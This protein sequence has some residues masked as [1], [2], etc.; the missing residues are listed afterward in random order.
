MHPKNS[1]SVCH[2]P[3]NFSVYFYFDLLFYYIE[4]ICYFELQSCNIEDDDINEA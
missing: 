4:V 1:S 3:F 2:L